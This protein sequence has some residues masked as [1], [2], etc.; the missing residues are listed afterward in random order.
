[1]ERGETVSSDQLRSIQDEWIKHALRRQE[2]IGL[3][4]VTDGEFRRRG[5]QRGFLDAVGG[6]V[7]KPGEYSFRNASGIVNVAP[8]FFAT[9]KLVRRKGIAT[10]EFEYVRKSARHTPKITLPSPTIFHFGLFRECVDKKVYPDI[11]EFFSEI[12]S[13]SIEKSSQ[14]FLR[15]VANTSSLMKWGCHYCATLT[16]APWSTGWAKTQ[17]RYSGGMST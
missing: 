2:E 10:D 16:S 4:L 3:A 5:W 15:L 14:H 6:F 1:M 12:S 17:T 11:E 8:A 13:R 7:T 9:Q